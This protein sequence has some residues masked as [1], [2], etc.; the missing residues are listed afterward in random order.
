M[1]ETSKIERV[2]SPVADFASAIGRKPETVTSVA[3]QHRESRAR[4][5]EGRG[6]HPVIALFKLHRHHLDRD[7]RI[8]D[9]QAEREHERAERDLVQADIEDV[10]AERGRREHQRDRDDDD[11][12]GTH[13]KA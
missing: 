5:G 13:A 10:H 7:D 9:K 8:V 2:Y 4:I 12:P 6:A 1:A 11:H 3:G